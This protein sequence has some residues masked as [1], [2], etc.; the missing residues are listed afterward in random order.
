VTGEIGEPIDP[1]GLTAEQVMGRVEEWI[2]SR[3]TVLCPA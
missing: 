2:E 3:M 1:A